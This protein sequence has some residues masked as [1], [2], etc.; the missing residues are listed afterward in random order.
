MD[1]SGGDYIFVCIYF[2]GYLSTYLFVSIDPDM[3]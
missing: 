1:G 3:A 2:S